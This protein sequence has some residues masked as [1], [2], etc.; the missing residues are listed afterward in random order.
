MERPAPAL[1]PLSRQSSHEV[2][3]WM[4]GG[5]RGGGGSG[6]YRVIS[7]QLGAIHQDTLGSVQIRNLARE[8]RHLTEI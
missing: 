6:T 2:F 5:V 7:I 4:I 8:P 1:Y 3:L